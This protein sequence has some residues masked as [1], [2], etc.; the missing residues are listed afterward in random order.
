MLRELGVEIGYVAS[1]YEFFPLHINEIR[2]SLELRG[3]EATIGQMDNEK[4][5]EIAG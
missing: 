1:Q 3:L 4:I 5:G 2:G